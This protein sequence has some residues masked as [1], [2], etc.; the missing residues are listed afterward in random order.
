MASLRLNFKRRY[1][2]II[3]IQPFFI[4]V[5]HNFSMLYIISENHKEHTIIMAQS[6]GQ[7]LLIGCGK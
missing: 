2:H 4:L 1:Q 7:S 6:V 3:K 5:L